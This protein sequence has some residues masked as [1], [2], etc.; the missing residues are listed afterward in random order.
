MTGPKTSNVRNEFIDS[1]KIIGNLTVVVA[2]LYTILLLME[3]ITFVRAI[4]NTAGSII[5]MIVC[6]ITYCVIQYCKSNAETW[7][8]NI[9]HKVKVFS[10]LTALACLAVVLFTQPFDIAINI[11]YIVA[12][13]G[14]SFGV[15]M[16][17][18]SGLFKWAI[19]INADPAPKKEVKS[20]K[21]ILKEDIVETMEELGDLQRTGKTKEEILKEEAHEEAERIAAEERAK[22][23][24]QARKIAEETAEAL[25]KTKKESIAAPVPTDPPAPTPIGETKNPKPLSKR[26]RKAKE[27]AEK[28]AKKKK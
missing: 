3:K 5:V 21:I 4:S 7:R 24:E 10:S 16:V 19:S 17:A 18:L 8:K 13:I 14:L 23:D 9:Q 28:L 26:E 22:A 11:A 20:K 25:K 1:L 12:I 27:M 15:M 6:L 2:I